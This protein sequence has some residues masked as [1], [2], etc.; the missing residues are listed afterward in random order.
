[1]NKTLYLLEEIMKKDHFIKGVIRG[2][3]ITAS[4]TAIGVAPNSPE[5]WVAFISLRVAVNV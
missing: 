4:L 2:M 5:F 1:M 3:A